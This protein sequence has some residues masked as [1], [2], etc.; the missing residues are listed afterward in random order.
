MNIYC[1]SWVYKSD[2]HFFRSQLGSLRHLLSAAGVLG[3]S[4]DLG[5]AP[6]CWGWLVE[7]RCSWGNQVPF[8]LVSHPPGCP[9][10]QLLM[11]VEVA[12][13][14]GSWNVYSI[15]HLTLEL[16]HYHFYCILLTGGSQE[17][18]PDSKGEENGLD[19]LMER[20]AKSCYDAWVYKGAQWRIGTNLT[21]LE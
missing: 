12:E 13:K 21:Q 17:A 20:I 1:W 15:G 18:S 3:S 14:K 6:M 9:L 8:H 7:D 4:V 19:L 16:V 5:W 2:G 11:E 10:R